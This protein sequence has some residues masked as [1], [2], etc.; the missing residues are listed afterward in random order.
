[1]NNQKKNI[2]HRLKIVTGHVR[3]IT[4]MVDKGAYCIDVLHQIQ[5]VK[6]ALG[7]IESKV[8]ENHMNTCVLDAFKKGRKNEAIKEVMSVFEK[9]RN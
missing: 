8:L 3:K 4:E 6:A 9:T 1:M 7:K 5:A 2:S